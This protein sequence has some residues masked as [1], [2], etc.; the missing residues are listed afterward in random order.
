MLT[1]PP[2]CT[3]QTSQQTNTHPTLNEPTQTLTNPIHLSRRRAPECRRAAPARRV[4]PTTKATTKKL[5]TRPK[6]NLQV[7]NLKLQK[8]AGIGID[9]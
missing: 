1:T 8:Q 9:Q 5:S 6:V 7:V 4:S 3:K 2:T